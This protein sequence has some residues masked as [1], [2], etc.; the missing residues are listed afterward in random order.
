MLIINPFTFAPKGPVGAGVREGFIHRTNRG[1]KFS[2]TKGSNKGRAAKYRVACRRCPPV[3]GEPIYAFVMKS[4]GKYAT[5]KNKHTFL[6]GVGAIP[7]NTY[8]EL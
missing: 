4:R 5:C 6:V 7:A 8:L 1:K 3:N 2:E